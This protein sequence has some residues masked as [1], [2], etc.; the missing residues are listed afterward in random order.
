LYPLHITQTGY[1][2]HPDLCPVGTGGPFPWERVK[3]LVCEVDHS[4]PTSVE[5]RNT[6][7][8]SSTPSYVFMAHLLY[9]N[10]IHEIMEISQRQIDEKGSQA[11]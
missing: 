2:G 4:P 5:I 11:N 10:F 9:I 1:G 6:C 3:W 7:T 8:Y